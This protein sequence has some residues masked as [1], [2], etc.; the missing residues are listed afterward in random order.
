[1]LN[2]PPNSASRELEN[3]NGT[4]QIMTNCSRRENGL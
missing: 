3:Y 2:S 4:R 1:L